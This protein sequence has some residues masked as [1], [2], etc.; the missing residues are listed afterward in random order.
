MLK[1]VF[2]SFMSTDFERRNPGENYSKGV[3]IN[4]YM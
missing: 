1:S 4:G 2:F 3:S